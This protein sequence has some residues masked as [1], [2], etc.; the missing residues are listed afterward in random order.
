[1]KY[2]LPFFLL[3][4]LNLSYSEVQAKDII[5][6][7]ATS[8][9]EAITQAAAKPN[10]AGTYIGTIPC[11]DCEGIKIELT[12]SENKA[13]KG[14]TYLLK[15]TYLGKPAG[16][17]TL[18]STGKWFAATGNSQDAKAVIYQLIP[19]RAYEPLYFRRVSDKAIEMLDQDQN[20]IASKAN[21]TLQKKQ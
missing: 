4:A 10:A 9:K 15:Q 11:A 1:M 2:M 14:R 12:L 17:N 8:T 5:Q 13:G 21:Y 19:D 3:A 18:Q 7:A 6:T 20:K 16:K